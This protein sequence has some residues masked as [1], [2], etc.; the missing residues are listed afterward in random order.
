MARILVVENDDDVAQ[1]V[2]RCLRTYGHS[3]TTARNGFLAKH[4][5][6]LDRPID[7]V[8]LDI[9][10]PGT[11]GFEVL[12]ELR[13]HPELNQP[14]LPAIFLSGS[15]RPEDEQQARA[16]NA[17]FLRKPFVSS[18]LQGAVIKAVSRG[19]EDLQ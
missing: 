16:L 17:T 2:A 6:G 13:R 1:L 4:L 18:E 8:L 9:N 10:L 19:D 3:V 5:V 14:R 12:K 11:N 7:L 15:S